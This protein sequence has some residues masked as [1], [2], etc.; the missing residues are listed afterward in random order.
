MHMYNVGQKGGV[1]VL[2]QRNKTFISR[3]GAWIIPWKAIK[4]SPIK[5]NSTQI[6]GGGGDFQKELLMVLVSGPR[7]GTESIVSCF[8]FYCL[9]LLGYNKYCINYDKECLVRCL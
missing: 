6:E 7:Q 1:L 2:D 4:I 3:E 9:F 8:S 5:R